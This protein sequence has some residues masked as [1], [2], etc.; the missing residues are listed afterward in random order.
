[1]VLFMAM[2]SVVKNE[3]RAMSLRRRDLRTLTLEE[4]LLR[5]PGGTVTRR[6]RLAAARDCGAGAGAAAA[7]EP[8]VI[9][10]WVKNSTEKR[11]WSTKVHG[12]K[13]TSRTHLAF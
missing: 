12:G 5:S 11:E 9:K 10:I 7:P 1:M 4:E 2:F 13:C 6:A 3:K 8:A